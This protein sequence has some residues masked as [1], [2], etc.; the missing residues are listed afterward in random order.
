MSFNLEGFSN[1]FLMLEHRIKLL[2]YKISTL[3]QNTAS[4][5]SLELLLENCKLKFKLMTEIKQMISA[6]YFWPSIDLASTDSSDSSESFTPWRNYIRI[7]YIP[8]SDTDS[9]FYEGES[10]EPY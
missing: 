5:R 1:D 8:D 4:K 9:S 10:S 7:G 6:G 3:P 2:T